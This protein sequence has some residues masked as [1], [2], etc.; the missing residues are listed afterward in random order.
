MLYPFQGKKVNERNIWLHAKSVSPLS[1]CHLLF[2]SSPLSPFFLALTCGWGFFAVVRKISREVKLQQ[3]PSTS[4]LEHKVLKYKIWKEL[5]NYN[6]FI[7]FMS[8]H[9]LDFFLNTNTIA[10]AFEAFTA[11]SQ[12][13]ERRRC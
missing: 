1:S 3:L 10:A 7:T 2:I 13:L 12:Y 4:S 8:L 6:I 11:S 5:S 9:L